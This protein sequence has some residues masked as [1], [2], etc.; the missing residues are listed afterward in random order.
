MNKVSRATCIVLLLLGC[1][2]APK[3]MATNLSA[4]IC[5]AGYVE[6]AEALSS[7][8]ELSDTEYQARF[9]HSRAEALAAV[10]N[11]EVLITHLNRLP[12]TDVTLHLHKV[13]ISAAGA[14]QRK[15]IEEL[16][17]RYKEAPGAVGRATLTAAQCGQYETVEYLLEVLGSPYAAA[18]NGATLASIALTE[19]DKQLAAIALQVGMDPCDAEFWGR[20]DAAKVRK[21]LATLIA[22]DRLW[23][24][25]EC[26]ASS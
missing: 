3:L 17:S 19:R 13:M 16:L 9:A 25:F 14:G 5:A 2:S 6:M 10:G 8:K 12:S 18:H 15:V 24:Q 4:P 22:E 7:A 1:D 23:E 11:T 21:T 20:A 26:R